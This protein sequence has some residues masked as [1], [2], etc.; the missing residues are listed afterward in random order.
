MLIKINASDAVQET[1]N[2]CTEQFHAQIVELSSDLYTVQVAGS[3]DELNAFIETIG[4]GNIAETV[5]TG[6]SGISKGV[7]ALSL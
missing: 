6:V 3:P 2:R 1:L 7:Q 5:R 4:Q